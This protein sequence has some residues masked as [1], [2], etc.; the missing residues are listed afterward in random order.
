MLKLKSV[1]CRVRFTVSKKKYTKTVRPL[2]VG[3]VSMEPEVSSAHRLPPEA[4]CD[5]SCITI[6]QEIMEQGSLLY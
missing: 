5:I 6:G 4:N 2:S 1:Q 3:H